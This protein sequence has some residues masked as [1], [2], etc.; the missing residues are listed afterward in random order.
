MQQANQVLRKYL[1]DQHRKREDSKTTEE[2]ETK[3]VPKAIAKN[4][5]AM[6]EEHFSQ[7]QKIY[8][9]KKK[10]L[11]IQ[12]LRENKKHEVLREILKEDSPQ[13]LKRRAIRAKSKAVIL[14]GKKFSELQK[15]LEH[16]AEMRRLQQEKEGPRGSMNKRSGHRIH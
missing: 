8:M 4:V 2:Y 15:K 12:V 13:E 9:Q 10:N 1:E 7:F 6:D 16:A 5:Y 14:N 11:E 3:Y